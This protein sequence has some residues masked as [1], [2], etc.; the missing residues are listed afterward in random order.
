MS[1]TAIET[2][3]ISQLPA[4]NAVGLLDTFP[5]LRAN[6]SS[7]MAANVAIMAQAIAPLVANIQ[8][9][10]SNTTILSSNNTSN[11]AF[12]ILNATNFVSMDVSADEGDNLTHALITVVADANTGQSNTVIQQ[13]AV[14]SNP[15]IFSGSIMAN[16][17]LNLLFQRTSNSTANVNFQYSY[18]SLTV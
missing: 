6:T 7:T 12:F 13:T 15:I 11:N 3:R 4:A 8:G 2:K 5:F 17:Y 16:T 18:K 10:I 9:W 14:G 1:N